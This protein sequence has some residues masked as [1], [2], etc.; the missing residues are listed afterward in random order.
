MKVITLSSIFLLLFLVLVAC[1]FKQAKLVPFY[2]T[3]EDENDQY[4]HKEEYSQD[5]KENILKVLKYYDVE[6]KLEG[7][8]IMIDRKEYENK[9]LMCNYTQKSMDED[10]LK[11]H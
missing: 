8:K 10:W 7:D 1:K 2:P 11:T 9:E 5:M 4:Y 3:Y 6:H